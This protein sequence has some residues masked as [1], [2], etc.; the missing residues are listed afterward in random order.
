MYE[1]DIMDTFEKTYCI[2]CE[3]DT[4]HRSEN[5]EE[6]ININGVEVTFNRI[7]KHC[8]ECKNI[9]YVEEDNKI[10]VKNANIAYRKKIGTIQVDE[11]KSLLAKYNIGKTTLA[12]LLGWGDITI[13]RYIEG[14]TPSKEYSDTLKS[15]LNKANMSSLLETNKGKITEIAYKKCKRALSKKTD[16]PLIDD[17][18]EGTLSNAASYF[19]SKDYEITPLALQKLLY[20][21]QGFYY[22]LRG[23]YLFDEDCEAS[24]H[25]PVY[26]NIYSKYSHFGHDPI[27]CQCSYD[28]SEEKISLLEGVLRSFGCYTGK[29]LEKFTHSEMPWNKAITAKRHE[30]TQNAIISKDF[31]GEYFTK[32]A[33]KYNIYNV[34]DIEVYSTTLKNKIS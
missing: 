23:D 24:A 33:E 21:A 31:I 7:K 8:I 15:L 11:I 14:S 34:Y 2:S 13:I 9:V 18:L 29:F 19:L 25:G 30:A 12:T 28:L 26:P 10:N 6:T 22:A 3:E 17:S 4:N 20:Y 1:E 32:V 16:E 5:K 27:K